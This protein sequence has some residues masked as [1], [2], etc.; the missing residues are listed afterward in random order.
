M[1]MNLYYPFE[2]LKDS[3]LLSDNLAK[4]IAQ[5]FLVEA[6]IGNATQISGF[7]CVP[8]STPMK[9]TVNKG[10]IFQLTNT[11]STNYGSLPADTTHKLLKQGI[12]RDPLDF[13][14]PAPT[15]AGQSINYLIEIIYNEAAGVIQNR[16]FRNPA[17]TPPNY[18]LDV[19][20]VLINNAIV[21][22]KAGIP[23][24][25]GNQQT[26]TPDA[27]YVGAWVITVAQGQNT[28][29][30]G[31]ITQYA[32]APF[33]NGLNNLT[34]ANLNALY[35]RLAAVNTFTQFQK[36]P[37]M[38]A[39]VYKATGQTIPAGNSPYKFNYDTIDFDTMGLWDS[40]NLRFKIPSAFPGYYRITSRLFC[41][42]TTTPT[43]G[44]NVLFL[45]GASYK[46]LN[47]SDN[48]SRDI[49]LNGST[50]VKCNADDFLEIYA[51]NSSST[52]GMNCNGGI[53]YNSFEIQYIG[54]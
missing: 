24:L 8:S 32:S 9:V 37:A 48:T 29:T 12:F 11:L 7:A 45:N 4:Q 16:A 15:T 54:S 2:S 50:L 19:N 13:A 21:A 49:T 3:D 40:A 20:T 38:C 35:A 52:A 27:G 23:A 42:A 46:R 47:E 34:P 5:G 36:M 30:S 10:S 28:I 39:S 44:Y 1:D 18:D 22:V 6:L 33:L 43:D 17:A 14:C 25:T 41:Q 31:N 26:P 51:V 53:G